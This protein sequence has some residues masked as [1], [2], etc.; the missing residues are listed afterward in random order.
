MVTPFNEEHISKP[1]R[2]RRSVPNYD[3]H[4]QIFKVMTELDLMC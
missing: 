4:S 2:G 1:I 3:V